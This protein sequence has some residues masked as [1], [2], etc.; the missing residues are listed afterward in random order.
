MPPSAASGSEGN[1]KLRKGQRVMF[2]NL[3]TRYRRAGASRNLFALVDEARRADDPLSHP[4]LRA[5]S[6]RE[7]ADLPPAR[8]TSHHGRALI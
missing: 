5:M 7:L 8:P 2:R 3:I 4:A 1:A 6:A